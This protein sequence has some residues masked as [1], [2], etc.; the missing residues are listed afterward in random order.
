MQVGDKISILGLVTPST[1]T[2]VHEDGSVD[3]KIEQEGH[4][5]NGTETHVLAGNFSTV[6]GSAPTVTA[7]SEA[8]TVKQENP[9]VTASAP[10]VEHLGQFTTVIRG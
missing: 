8:Q 6:D 5:A 1:V 7:T 10:K 3:A 2:A 4:P 9:T